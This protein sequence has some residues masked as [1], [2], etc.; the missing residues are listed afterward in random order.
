[1]A[2]SKVL[3]AE[4]YPIVSSHLQKK[5]NITRLKRGIES[6]LD[7]NNDK[8]TTLGPIHRTVFLDSDMKV[9]Y[10]ATGLNPQTIKAVL[11]K[12]N[13][14]GDDWKII[15]NPF[16][17]ASMMAI[18]Y[19]KMVKNKDMA[20]LT[21]IY[22][23]LSMYPSLHFKYFQHEPNEKIMNYTI[24]NL[25]NKYK[26]KKAGVF[27]IALIE[28]AE[29]A[30][31]NH[32]DR[33]LRG[34]D[35]DFVNYINDVKTRVNMMIRKISNEFYENKEKELYINI[36]QE[37][38]EED[39]YREAESNIYAIEKL[40]NGVVLKLIVNGP[41]MKLV[42]AAAKLCKV[43]VSELR[44]YASSM[45]TSENKDEIKQIVESI[46]FLYL[47]DD[48]NR[49]QEI[50]SDKF[51]MYCMDIYK[52]SNTTDKNIINI[53]SILD[54]WLERLGTY[55]KTQRLNTINDFRRALYIFF[56]VSI[57]Y[58]NLN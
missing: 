45:I 31:I 1:M 2:N 10:D 5:E 17:V 51:L 47:F 6:Y 26:I 19:F 13:D 3:V 41:N 15:N 35:K 44:N 22:L 20:K 36:E 38:M 39:N 11:K 57:Q 34:E 54:G 24:N 9:L 18:R 12:C 16:N 46:L 33:L 7:R 50:N 23:T 37:S 55:K 29:G 52:K 27:Y 56:V 28:T 48:K 40:S 21:L 58:S 14:V 25:S 4:L 49:L 8:L 32:H 43:S 30:D 53:K 42:T